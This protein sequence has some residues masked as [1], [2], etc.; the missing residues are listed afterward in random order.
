M[1][2]MQH[3]PGAWRRARVHDAGLAEVGW[4]CAPRGL[5]VRRAVDAIISADAGSAAS[6]GLTAR[7]A[8]GAACRTASCATRVAVALPSRPS[9][10]AM[11]LA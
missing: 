10:F 7:A 1:G 11:R 5:R 9:I 8:S 6:V 3:D 2:R 4:K